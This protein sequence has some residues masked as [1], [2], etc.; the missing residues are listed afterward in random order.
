M[1][2]NLITADNGSGLSVDIQILRS[3]FEPAGHE[4]FFTPWQSG[5]KPKGSFDVNIFLELFNPLHLSSAKRNFGIFNQEWFMVDWLAQIIRLDNVLCK[6]RHAQE[7]FNPWA[8]CTYTS[9]TSRDLYDASVKRIPEFL[10]LRGRSRTKGT[11][12]ALRAWKLNPSLPKLHIYYNK[13]FIKEEAAVISAEGLGSLPNVEFHFGFMSEAELFAVYNRY[14]FH[15]CPSPCEGFGHYINE[16]LSCGAVVLTTEAPPMN[17]LIFAGITGFT[18]KH[19]FLE[20]HHAGW[21]FHPEPG[22]IAEEAWKMAS[23]GQ[24]EIKRYSEAGRVDFELR[25]KQ[26]R[27]RILEI[28]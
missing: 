23:L 22:S 18:A 7:I 5:E 13:E 1:K 11:M 4:V 26:A 21:M 9:F 25:D 6:T 12:E 27:K 14:Q 17:E 24:N 3:I 15:L 2:I 16:G 20:P 19:Y 10:H 28:L 8:N